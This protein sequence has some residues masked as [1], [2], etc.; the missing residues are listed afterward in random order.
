MEDQVISLRIPSD[1]AGLARQEAESNDLTLSQVVRKA[2]RVYFA[3]QN[4]PS[5]GGKGEQE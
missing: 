3:R 1:L 4:H 5:R 2:L